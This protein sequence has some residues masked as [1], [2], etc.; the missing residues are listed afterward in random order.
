MLREVRPSSDF[1][2]ATARSEERACL[3]NLCK[4]LANDTIANGGFVPVTW[5]KHSSSAIQQQRIKLLN[6][7]EPPTREGEQRKRK[8][9]AGRMEMQVQDILPAHYSRDIPKM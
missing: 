7:C 9:N 3:K 2:R 1:Y 4:F 5:G 8:R 6:F